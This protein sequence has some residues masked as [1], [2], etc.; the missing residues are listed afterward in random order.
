MGAASHPDLGDRGCENCRGPAR[1]TYGEMAADR[2]ADARDTRPVRLAPAIL[3][4]LMLRGCRS[5]RIGLGR[6]GHLG[7]RAIA[8]VIDLEAVVER[9]QAHAKNIR[10]LA[11]DLTALR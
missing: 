8:T 10:R 5:G 11:L 1:H 4:R 9:L 2:A 7:L 6:L 3:A